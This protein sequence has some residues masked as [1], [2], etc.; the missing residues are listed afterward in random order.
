[1]SYCWSSGRQLYRFLKYVLENHRT[2]AASALG[3]ILLGGLQGEILYRFL[4]HVLE[5]RRT[6]GPNAL[7]LVSLSQSTC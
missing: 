1:M 7:G 3:Q 5:N 4:K 6:S 2:S